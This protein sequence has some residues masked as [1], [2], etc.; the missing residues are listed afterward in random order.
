MAQECG[1]EGVQVHSRLHACVLNPRTGIHVGIAQYVGPGKAGY[2]RATIVQLRKYGIGM[3]RLCAHDSGNSNLLQSLA[4]D[5]TVQ[6]TLART[7]RKLI[8][9]ID[10]PAMPNVVIGVPSKDQVRI[11]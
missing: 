11:S 1:T 7:E 9:E 6:I 10:D 8:R 4:Q 2:S 3:P 5:A